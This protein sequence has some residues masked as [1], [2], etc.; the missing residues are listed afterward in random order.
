MESGGGE[1]PWGVSTITMRAPTRVG[2]GGG[3]WERGGY[4]TGN[5]PG[6]RDGHIKAKEVSL[7]DLLERL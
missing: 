6:A 7:L 2:L 1:A 4:V 3:T 5:L